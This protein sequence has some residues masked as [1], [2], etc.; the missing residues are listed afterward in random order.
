MGWEPRYLDRNRPSAPR[1]QE[2]ALQCQPHPDVC[3]AEGACQIGTHSMTLFRYS[4]RFYSF[5]IVPC[6]SR[7]TL[8]AR[9]TEECPS[10]QTGS[11]WARET[12]G[13]HPLG[14]YG[15]FRRRVLSL[16]VSLLILKDKGTVDCARQEHLRA[17]S[18][19]Q[20]NKKKRTTRGLRIWSPT[21]LL[22]ALYAA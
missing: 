22:T 2:W 20:K 10:E 11:K 4:S 16:F 3:C 13:P 5:P 9:S 19:K 21:I 17:P 14:I 8:Q 15:V 18:A 6:L 12:H 7:I 1:L